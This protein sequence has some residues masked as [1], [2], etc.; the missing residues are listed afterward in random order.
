MKFSINI[1]IN[2]ESMQM[3][4]LFDKSKRLRVMYYAAL[5]ALYMFGIAA[6]IRACSG[7]S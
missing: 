4:E 6:I 7:A 2:K 3:L 1:S 5:V